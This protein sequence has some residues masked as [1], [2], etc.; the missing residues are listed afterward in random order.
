MRK[1]S[2][3]AQQAVFDTSSMGSKESMKI[4]LKQNFQFPL[5]SSELGEIK[6]RRKY[7]DIVGGEGL[8][9]MDRNVPGNIYQMGSLLNAISQ[10]HQNRESLRDDQINRTHRTLLNHNMNLNEHVKSL[11]QKKRMEQHQRT[12]YMNAHSLDRSPS[13]H[14]A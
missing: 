3:R 11:T 1:N 13:P 14:F 9:E 8:P 7:N 4:N 5:K 12:S 6:K 2:L 10:K